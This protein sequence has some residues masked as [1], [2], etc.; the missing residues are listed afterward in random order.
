VTALVLDP[1]LELLDPALEVL[2]LVPDELD[3]VAWAVGDAVAIRL[4]D[5]S[6]GS[7]PVTSCTKITPQ[8]ATN[9]A[10]TSASAL[11]RIR[12]TRW[13]RAR[14]RSRPSALPDRRLSTGP[15]RGSG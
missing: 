9:S 12:R 2:P 1:E 15:R 14:S 4:E 13:R 11:T 10:T 5:A 8:I 7:W 6:A 3:C